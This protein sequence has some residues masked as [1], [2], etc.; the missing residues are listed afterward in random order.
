MNEV[1][2]YTKHYRKTYILYLVL[3]KN[4]FPFLGNQVKHFLQPKSEK[5]I[6]SFAL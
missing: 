4:Q 1:V 6:Y 2:L 5:T 3:A